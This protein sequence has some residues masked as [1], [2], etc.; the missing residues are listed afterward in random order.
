[1]STISIIATVLNEVETIDRLV[2]SLLQQSLQP[3]EIVI[4][5]GGSADGTWEKLEAL[6]RSAPLLKVFRDES[7]NLKRS[8]GPIARGRNVAIAAA[9]GQVIACCDAGC[10]YGEDWLA[11]LVAPITLG[12]AEYVLGGSCIDA[13]QA[14]AWDLAAA[15]LMGIATQA[16]GVR[17]SCTARSMAFTKSLWERVGG[18]PEDTLL[19]ED[20]VFDQRVQ[21]LVH[22]AYAE[23][24]MA[25]YSPRF[26]YRT[27][28]DTLARYSAADGALEIRAAR[29]VRMMLRCVAQMVAIV[30]LRWSVVPLLIVLVLE[31]LFAFERDRSVLRPK[32][33][34]ALLPRIVFSVSVPWITAFHYLRGRLKPSNRPNPQNA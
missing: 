29:F 25:L 8:P 19:G 11:R 4:V 23:S 12:Q 27:A 17:K 5:D 34:R 15:P 20:S 31:L 28:C 14:T 10:R 3:I 32:G 26:T 9:C 18:F 7:C 30:L 1:M 2:R 16:E 24:A 13:A 21:K 22:P 6:A 33:W